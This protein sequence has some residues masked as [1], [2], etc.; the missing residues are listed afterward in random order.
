MTNQEI[1]SI[2]NDMSLDELK[3]LQAYYNKYIND[4]KLI[5]NAKA[6]LVECQENKSRKVEPTKREIKIEDNINKAVK[7]PKR[8]KYKISAN[9]DGRKINQLIIDNQSFDIDVLDNTNYLRL[10]FQVKK[11]NLANNEPF[12]IISIISLLCAINASFV[13]LILN[14]SSKIVII[15]QLLLL[16]TAA[17]TG[18][19]YVKT[20]KSKLTIVPKKHISQ[21]QLGKFIKMLNQDYTKEI[22]NSKKIHENNLAFNLSKEGIFKNIIE[23]NE[24]ELKT[25]IENIRTLLQ[26]EEKASTLT[27]EEIA[28]A[29]QCIKKARQKTYKL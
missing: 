26:S 17:L 18:Y 10:F 25:I 5:N 7:L 19:K 28:G 16:A 2:L 1:Q 12:I 8:S 3:Q 6:R 21:S 27:A 14:A 22:E 20:S 9:L 13:M 23:T 11:K 24:E 29:E 15:L 4:T